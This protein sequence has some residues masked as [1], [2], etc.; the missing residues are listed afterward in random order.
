MPEKKL[1]GDEYSEFLRARFWL[2]G[3]EGAYLG[4]GRVTLL[5]KIDQF[6]S[7]NAAAKEMKMSYKKAW[8]LVEEMNEMFSEPLVVKAHGG[9]SG[10]GTQLTDKGQQAVKQFLEI[11]ARLKV[12]LQAESNQ[13]NL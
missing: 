12:F 13:I 1:P 9:K 4:I 11:E 3:K 10:G 2:V 6:G 5:Q 7:I 8:K